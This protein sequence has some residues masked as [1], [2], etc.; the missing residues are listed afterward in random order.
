MIL[1]SDLKKKQM[2][3]FSI[4]PKIKIENPRNISLQKQKNENWTKDFERRLVVRG[5][6]LYASNGYCITCKNIQLLE[7]WSF[8]KFL[9]FWMKKCMNCFWSLK[10]SLTYR[11]NLSPSNSDWSCF[12]HCVRSFVFRPFLA[13][14]HNNGTIHR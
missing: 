1:R 8:K 5:R 14:F 13:P 3:M 2:T 6:H 10:C 7:I 4:L 12:K 9:Q 11:S